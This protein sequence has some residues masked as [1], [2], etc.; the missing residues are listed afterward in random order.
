MSQT[1]TIPQHT[2]DHYNAHYN[3]QTYRALSEALAS[4]LGLDE[5]VTQLETYDERHN[6]IMNLLIDASMELVGAEFYAGAG[7]RLGNAL[8]TLDDHTSTLVKLAS[9]HLDNFATGERPWK[10]REQIAH[11]ATLA[12]AE[13]ARRALVRTLDHA[14]L[15]PGWQGTAPYYW[16]LAC[17]QIIRSAE[18]VLQG[19]PSA[20]YL[21]EKFGK[22]L[23]MLGT[24]TGEIVHYGNPH[25]V[26]R[27]FHERLT[28]Q[29]KEG[30]HV[31]R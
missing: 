11:M 17:T 5:R 22:A 12:L 2:L 25:P 24:G 13:L 28:A 26:I 30:C 3:N 1:T 27:Q 16:L 7:Q 9:D 8:G 21:V 10:I 29:D 23:E 19:D 14:A 4:A 15:L 6:Q 31:S 20:D 18:I